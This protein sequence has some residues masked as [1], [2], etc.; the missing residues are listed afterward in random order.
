MNVDAAYA[1]WRSCYDGFEV[2]LSGSPGSHPYR[3]GDLW[4]CVGRWFAGDWYTPEADQYIDLV[5]EYMSEQVW[6]QPYFAT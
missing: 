2:W 3:A 1:I 4:G 5:K 6:L